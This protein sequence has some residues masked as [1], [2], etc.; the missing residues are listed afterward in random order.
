ML[1]PGM[2]SAVVQRECTSRGRYFFDIPSST[3]KIH[4]ANTWLISGF[5]LMQLNRV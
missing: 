5:Y 2:D 3:S 4:S 1:V